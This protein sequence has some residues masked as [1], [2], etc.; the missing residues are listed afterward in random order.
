[1]SALD[2]FVGDWLTAAI[3]AKLAT[4]RP[5]PAPRGPV[6]VA[7]GN[8]Q[9]A[10]FQGGEEERV[11]VGLEPRS[12][13]GGLTSGAPG[14][15]SLAPERPTQVAAPFAT[16]RQRYV[17]F[18]RAL[19]AAGTA[20]NLR[21]IEAQRRVFSLFRD[22]AIAL[23]TARD[24]DGQAAHGSHSLIIDGDLELVDPE[25][26]DYMHGCLLKFR[27]SVDLPLLGEEAETIRVVETPVE[28]GETGAG[29]VVQACNSAG[30]Q[31]QTVAESD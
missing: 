16:V 23:D 15:R 18:C 31:C 21:V 5:G 10:Q 8:E 17:I 30:D 2:A 13:I 25:A 7:Y 24:S 3:A 22:V 6:L 27:V 29:F 9:D 12:K 26:A 14:R 20:E 19:P 28:P 1:M 4:R 11:V